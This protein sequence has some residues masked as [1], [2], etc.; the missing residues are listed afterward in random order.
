M[1]L[2][3]RLVGCPFPRIKFEFTES[4]IFLSLFFFFI[5][6][7]VRSRKF[8]FVSLG[9]SLICHFGKFIGLCE[10]FLAL[11]T[12]KSIYFW[13]IVDF[14]F[15]FFIQPHIP[16]Y[17]FQIYFRRQH[18]RKK[19]TKQNFPPSERKTDFECKQ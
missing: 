19:K 14:F 7:L 16:L 1:A 15:F 18:E 13:W 2:A 10:A 8:I 12:E 11:W 3:K 5:F 6:C 17:A 9:F 4:Y